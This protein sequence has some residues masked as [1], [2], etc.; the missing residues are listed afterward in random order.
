MQNFESKLFPG[1][2][3][4][5]TAGTEGIKLEVVLKWRDIYFESIIVVSLVDG[6]KMEGIVK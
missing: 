3:V 6:L 2:K 4:Q 1:Y 5:I